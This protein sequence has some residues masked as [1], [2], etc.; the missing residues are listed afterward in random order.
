MAVLRQ[1]VMCVT[2]LFPWVYKPI[3]IFLRLSQRC[4]ATAM[5]GEF[6]SENNFFSMAMPASMK[7]RTVRSHL[8]TLRTVATPN[9]QHWEAM[10]KDGSAP[11]KLIKSHVN[12]Y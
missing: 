12:G 11:E 8:S 1:R 2:A 10:Q 3:E 9:K 6:A 5:G 7:A 4:D